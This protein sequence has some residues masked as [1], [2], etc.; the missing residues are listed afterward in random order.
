MRTEPKFIAA[1]PVAT[2]R[3]PA[4]DSARRLRELDA[5]I[6]QANWTVDLMED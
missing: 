4:D 3:R 5:M 2:M 1:V 6:Q